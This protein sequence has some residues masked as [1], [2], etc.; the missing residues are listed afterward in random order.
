[1]TGNPAR[2][3]RSNTADNQINLYDGD[4]NAD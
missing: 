2:L 1:V 4:S 3:R